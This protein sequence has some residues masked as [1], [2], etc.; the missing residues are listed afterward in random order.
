MQQGTAARPDPVTRPYGRYELTAQ[1][2]VDGGY[3]IT[4]MTRTGGNREHGLSFTVAD[5]DVYRT[6]YAVI[7]EGGLNN[8]HP[9]GV[10]DAIRD[11]LTRDLHEAQ[12]RRDTASQ[13]QADYLND[14]LDRF[15]SP[16]DTAKV[17]ELVESLSQPTRP[18]TFRELRDAHAAAAARDR[19]QRKAARR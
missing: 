4:T 11:A 13:A 10:R 12:R 19:A 14:L 2:T 18:R 6:I 9:D 16:E 5:R 17:T 7:R 3:S 8:V 1:I 15:E